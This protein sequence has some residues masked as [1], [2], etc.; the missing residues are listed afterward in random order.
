[1]SKNH[2]KNAFFRFFEKKQAIFGVMSCFLV[3]NEQN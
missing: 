3:K 2:K 1:M